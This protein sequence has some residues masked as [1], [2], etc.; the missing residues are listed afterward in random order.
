MRRQAPIENSPYLRRRRAG[1]E[2]P[3]CQLCESFKNNCRAG[4]RDRPHCSAFV[5]VRFFFCEHVRKWLALHACPA[6]RR[7]HPPRRGKHNACVRTC[8]VHR[9]VAG[10]ISE[11]REVSK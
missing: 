10:I 8:K 3:T 1:T 11:Q 4:A 7:L 5:P 9:M 6:Y 2:T